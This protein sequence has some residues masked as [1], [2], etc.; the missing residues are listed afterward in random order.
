MERANGVTLLSMAIVNTHTFMERANGVTLLSM[1]IVN[2][3]L[4]GKG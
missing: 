2:T 4:H 1:A 3:H